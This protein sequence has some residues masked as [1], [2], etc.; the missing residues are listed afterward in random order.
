MKRFQRSWLTPPLTV[1]A[2]VFAIAPVE[3]AETRWFRMGFTPFNYDASEEAQ[4]TVYGLINARQDLIAHHLDDGIP[5]PEASAGTAY[6]PNVEGELNERLGATPSGMTIY[7]ATTPISSG[8]DDLAN[9][10]AENG[11]MPRPTPVS[12][13]TSDAMAL[14]S[15]ALATHRFNSAVFHR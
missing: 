8:R 1:L 11:N 5:W 4:Q 12:G 9:Y 10:G 14:R 6:H 13:L 2:L 7:L 3:A 15:G